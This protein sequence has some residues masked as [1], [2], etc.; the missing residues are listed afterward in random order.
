MM[1]VIFL[2]FFIGIFSLNIHAQTAYIAG[3]GDNT[4]HVIDVTSSTIVSTVAV[5]NF[6]IGIAISPDESNVY[7]TNYVDGTVSVIDA[8]SNTVTATIV[9]GGFP[10][11]IAVSPDGNSIYVGFLDGSM[12]TVIDAVTNTV[13]TT[14]AGTEMV[15]ELEFSPDGSTAIAPNTNSNSLTVIDVAT[16]TVLSTIIV[17][18]SPTGVAISPDG[19]R[20]YVSNLHDNNI[21]VIDAATYTV[22]ET[23]VVGSNPYCVAISPD[24]SRVF[25][26]NYDDGTVSVIDATTNTVIETITVGVYPIGISVSVDG[27]IVYA[28]NTSDN[29][30]SII[31]VATNTVTGTITGIS[32]PYNFGN[33]FS[34][35]V[36]GSSNN[37]PTAVASSING[38]EN[39]NYAFSAS[40]FNYADTDNDAMA[41]IQV[42]SIPNLGVLFNDVNLNN[43]VDGGETIVANDVI[44]KTDIDAGQLKYSSVSE[45]V[46]GN[47][48]STF[49]FMVNDGTDYSSSAYTMTLN[50]LRPTWNGTD[51]WTN[52]ANWNIGVVPS[53][54]SNIYIQSGTV[55]FTSDFTAKSIYYTTPASYTV[56]NGSTLTVTDD[57]YED[58]TTRI[59][60]NSNSIQISSSIE[61]N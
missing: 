7:V 3:L 2:L 33:F 25:N 26:T 41:Q 20:I 51:D 42:T 50:I 35:R 9:V 38:I 47:A 46:Y 29:S 16:N 56:T 61:L 60:L 1:R 14:I 8:T 28:A 13:I 40:N 58:N 49:N 45:D 37:L 4:V 10:S 39:V 57:I 12:I 55:T 59:Q 23:I 27:T 15:Y 44:T 32:A 31:D 5:G 11:S 18:N 48:Y 36:Q 21:S 54:N 53:A 6:P 17:G 22:I 19:T 43:T 34:S 24:G 30:V 52:T